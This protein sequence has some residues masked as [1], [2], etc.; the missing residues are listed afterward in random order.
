MAKQAV[1]SA[2]KAVTDSKK[3]EAQIGFWKKVVL[4]FTSDSNKA[5]QRSF[6]RNRHKR[7]LQQRGG[8]KEKEE[9]LKH[10]QKRNR[11]PFLIYLFRE[12]NIK[13]NFDFKN[14]PLKDYQTNIA[15][16]VTLTIVDPILFI[17]DYMVDSNDGMTN[18][19]LIESL[20][21]HMESSLV[22]VI[23]SFDIQSIKYNDELKL[24]LKN[25][26]N[27]KLSEYHSSLMVSDISELA[28]E[29]A[30]IEQMTRERSEN[31]LLEKQLDQKNARNQIINLYATTNNEQEIEAD[32]IE[33]KRESGLW[34]NEKNRLILEEEVK[35]FKLLLEKEE[36]LL[37]AKT[38][39][40]IKSAKADLIK[41]GLLREQDVN[42]LERKINEENEDHDSLRRHSLNMIQL[43]QLIE[44]ESLELNHDIDKRR[45]ELE[46]N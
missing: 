36:L 20:K 2:K 31:Y 22:N 4:F 5:A 6:I 11:D 10:I 33:I 37:N 16:S 38:E 18:R 13:L 24:S 43:N 8:F 30:I 45:T 26:I 41:V 32:L 7:R 17:G 42:I 12:K 27:E 25:N 3:A 1:E 40:E 15:M 46:L 28:Y 44:H 34:S 21:S 29:D 14:I 19:V 23:K 39:D 35:R 9:F